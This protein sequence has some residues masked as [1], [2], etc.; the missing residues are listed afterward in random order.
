[1]LA[2][3]TATPTMFHAVPEREAAIIRIGVAIMARARPTP[4]LRLLAISSPTLGGR[5]SDVLSSFISGCIV[6]ESIRVSTENLISR[7]AQKALAGSGEKPALPTPNLASLTSCEPEQASQN[8]IQLG[9]SEHGRDCKINEAV[10]E[11]NQTRDDR[12][13]V[14]A[15]VELN[16]PPRAGPGGSGQP[17]LYYISK[18]ESGP[19]NALIQSPPEQTKL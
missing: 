12:G 17:K 5:C 14:S 2:A 8:C 7:K 10:G 6:H 16:S 9:N 3:K 1:M 4:W 13:M 11:Q 18:R 19:S 15:N